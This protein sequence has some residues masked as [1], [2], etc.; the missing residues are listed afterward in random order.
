MHPI[1]QG[2]LLFSHRALF[3]F[4]KVWPTGICYPPLL[5]SRAV[6]CM[7]GYVHDTVVHGVSVGEQCI[8]PLR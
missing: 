1:P 6:I 3:P 5:S 4:K 2:Y 8:I 7:M